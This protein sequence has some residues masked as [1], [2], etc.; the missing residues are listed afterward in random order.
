MGFVRG[1]RIEWN[2]WWGLKDIALRLFSGVLPDPLDEHARFINRH[3]HQLKD[4]AAYRALVL[5]GEP[6]MGKSSELDRE[7]ARRRSAG[8]RVEY[9]LLRE[10]LTPGEVAEEIREAA[11]RWAQSGSRGDLTL[12]FDGFDEPLFAI[13]NLAQVLKRELERLD[14]GRL[15]VLITSRRS[16]WQD[17]L[18][19]AFAQ[20][21]PDGAT[22][23][24]VLAPL[25]ER[26][27]KQAAATEL[28][29]PDGFVARLKA[30]DVQLLAA[31]PMTLRLL[32]AAHTKGEMPFQRSELYR[33]G[34]EGLATEIKASEGAAGRTDPPVRLRL[35]AARR[36]ASVSLLSGRDQ[37]IW[38]SG[39]LQGEG[40]V[41]LDEVADADVSL[42]SLEAVFGSA[43]LTDGR[44]GRGWT[45]RSVQ[46]FLT[47]QQCE[48]LPLASVR[49]L[50]ADPAHPDRVLPQLAGVA[51]WLAVLRSD[52]AD[53]LAAAE[54]EVLMQA[55]L[56]CFPEA[57][58]ARVAEAIV[59]KVASTP[60]PGI[61]FGY[62]GLLYP[63]LGRQ[64]APLL[65]AGEPVWRQQEAALIIR[66]TELRDLDGLLMD[67]VE[68]CAGERGREDYDEGVQ[69]AEW[70]AR[71]LRGTDEEQVLSRARR[72]AADPACPWPVRAE[73]LSVL[74]P[75]HVD[76]AW[77]LETVDEADRV[78][79][80]GM[81]QRFVAML[82]RQERAGGCRIEDLAAWAAPLP[83][84]SYGDTAVRRLLSR[85]AWKAISA[86]EVGSSQWRAAA[87][88]L[89]ALLTRHGSVHGVDET[90]I[91]SLE[92][93]RRRHLVK[94][95]V[96]RA[97]NG[98]A[99][100]ARMLEAELLSVA[101]VQWWL[102]DLRDC[103]PE[104]AD[105]APAFFALYAL[106]NV[107]DDEDARRVAAAAE[108][109]T[110]R[111]TALAER[112]T[113]VADSDRRAGRRAAP[114]Q[115]ADLSR[116]VEEALG[117][118]QFSVLVR[119]LQDAAGAAG[120]G[121]P[122]AAW[123]ALGAGQQQT[124]AERAVS[125]L[126]CGPDAADEATAE[127]IEVAYRIIEAC[128]RT[129]LDRVPAA[130]WAQWLPGLSD[131][132][133]GYGLL[134][135]ALDRAASTD[136]DAVIGFLIQKMRQDVPS[137]AFHQRRLQAKPLSE[138]ALALLE[139]G[140]HSAR[141]AA[142]LLDIAAVALPEQTA[143]VALDLLQRNS[144]P[145]SSDHG[146]QR[147][148][149]MAVVAGACLAACPLSPAVFDALLGI[150]QSNLPLAQEIIRQVN[151]NGHH[152]WASLTHSQRGRLYLW[153]N[154][155]MPR[156][157]VAPET[158]V[159]S[160]VVDDFPSQLLVLVLDEPSVENAALL[161]DLA[162]KTGRV[163]LRA[164]AAQM[165]DEMRA[166]AWRPPTPAEVLDVLTAPSRRIITSQEQ[167]A[168]VLTETFQEIAEA[169]RAD[170]AVRA[171]LWHRQRRD[172]TW[173]SYVPMEEREV[174]NWLARELRHRLHRR[175]AVLR[176]VEINPNL[177]DTQGDIPD[178][179]A[180]A[181]TTGEQALSVACE[182]KCSWHSEFVKAI[183]DQL[184]LRY[185]QGPNGRA[186]VYVAVYFSGSA[187]DSGDSRRGKYTSRRPKQVSEDL[188]R[189]AAE[190][191]GRGI[192]AHV[193]VLDASLDADEQCA[194]R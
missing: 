104:R 12:A 17:Q 1:D 42:T 40:A 122:V 173:V 75:G 134:S 108:A 32:L 62:G 47:A 77:L 124:V 19:T 111:W 193:C 72:L 70:A 18:S 45:H 87:G 41:G 11:G 120:G 144:G 176:E 137:V 179:L 10:F 183:Q 57:R 153:A 129:L 59:A 98:H 110:P 73:L 48:S 125:F 27:I 135:V 89:D 194:E 69:A 4:F 8:E 90:G 35:E 164:D 114:V 157:I 16:A 148:Y 36:L 2:R 25:A 68:R 99:A 182:V 61:R 106:A 167:F 33:L 21:W 66:A 190:L 15:R 174:S 86:A 63:G 154:Q 141:T 160:D 52:V 161:E 163:W 171:Q 172:N 140:N 168:A 43:L 162:E 54:P 29:D 103:A 123:R 152:T 34:V 7:V 80:R 44:A 175:A 133:G 49:N 39:P 83:S 101:D 145:L 136:E 158:I 65:R 31:S 192:T 132:P 14:L 22:A 94:E 38:R 81:G 30:V 147:E 28:D 6:G 146:D 96:A 131:L 76:M 166:Q 93:E 60:M 105:S 88:L 82:G 127:L 184:G 84:G 85:P 78:P 74:W 186:G 138:Q 191:A 113:A 37:V 24:L 128:D 143:Q 155:A 5:L 117:A 64:L 188:R 150:L 180:V 119:A 53:W 46:E 50:L 178:L 91:G 115:E 23:C 118:S 112:F 149:D 169:L 189:Y 20:W 107:V 139:S 126:S 159:G 185:L 116:D 109:V 92:P 156:K 177:A 51:A 102:D 151:R 165:R 3:V 13:G 79:H 55:N 170:R 58:R 67:L 97:G 56:R 100:A 9:I 130:L 95:V 181:H 71:A 187:W 26:D 121:S 142:G